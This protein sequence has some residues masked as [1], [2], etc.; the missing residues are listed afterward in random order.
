MGQVMR[1]VDEALNRAMAEESEQL[2]R[3]RIR[4]A[5]LEHALGD[6]SRELA[7]Q[8]QQQHTAMELDTT[9]FDLLRQLVTIK[10]LDDKADSNQLYTDNTTL[11][12]LVG[13]FSVHI[14]HPIFICFLLL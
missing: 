13:W 14:C 7:A 10:T 4:N 3:R 5:V 9:R 1:I 12:R 2:T 11:R 6:Q 8:K